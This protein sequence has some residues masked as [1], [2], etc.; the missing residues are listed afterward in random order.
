MNWTLQSKQ[1]KLTIKKLTMNE[2]FKSIFKWT[3]NCLTCMNIF[4]LRRT[5]ELLLLLLQSWTYIHTSSALEPR[6]WLKI[7]IRKN[8]V[9]QFRASQWWAG[10]RV[11]SAAE[12]CISLAL[13]LPFYILH[14]LQVRLLDSPA[15][16]KSNDCYLLDS[17][18]NAGIAG[19]T[20][21]T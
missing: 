15:A 16:Q 7:K 10:C 13:R 14:L 11:G 5:H 8:L 21:K 9:L 19:L 20:G 6:P 12:Q 1:N 17:E 3:E 18:L 4:S 2:I